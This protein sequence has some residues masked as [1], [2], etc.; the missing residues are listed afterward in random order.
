[1]ADRQARVLVGLG[2]Q[3]RIDEEMAR[4]HGERAEHAR[5]GDA[6]RPQ[7]RD[8]AH[9]HVGRVQAQT[10]RRTSPSGVGVGIRG[11]VL[12]PQHR[13][14]VESGAIRRL[15]IRRAGNSA[16]GQRKLARRSLGSRHP[17]A[18]STQRRHWGKV[19]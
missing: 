5:M 15:A 9:A 14:A 10:D 19:A 2:R 1:M 3:R 11:V 7:S 12:R 18:L 4:H 8:H 6:F 16:E 17:A 13:T